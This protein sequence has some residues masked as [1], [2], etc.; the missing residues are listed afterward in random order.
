MGCQNFL[1][2]V[3][4]FFSEREYSGADWPD[5][6]ILL[7]VHGFCVVVYILIYLVISLAHR[8][9]IPFW[10]SGC[11]LFGWLGLAPPVYLHWH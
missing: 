4:G 7:L 10:L 2:T 3:G 1:F 6:L 9:N 8:P 5:L 11:L